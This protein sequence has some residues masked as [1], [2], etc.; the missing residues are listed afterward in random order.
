MPRS[1]Q[2]TAVSEDVSAT[3]EAVRVAVRKRS[4][5]HSAAEVPPAGASSPVAEAAELAA[6]S[7]HLPVTWDTPVFGRA[8]ALSKRAMRLALRWYINPI[9]EQQNA[10]NDAVVRVLV[11]LEARQEQL[12]RRID[13]L[14]G[15]QR[16]P[17]E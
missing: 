3:L 4:G 16:P 2:A 14:D 10:F 12:A 8:I 17:S 5:Y 7:A 1:E 9:I 15:G 13:A 6:V 11:T